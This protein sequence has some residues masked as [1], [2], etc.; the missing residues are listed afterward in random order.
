VLT[1]TGGHMV[2]PEYYSDTFARLAKSAGLPPIWLHDLRRASGITMLDSGVPVH[3]A[4]AWHGHDPS[5]TL[6][7]YGHVHPVG[8]ADAGSALGAAFE[9]R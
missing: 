2:R 9:Q 1:D 5:M 4:A 7:V 8:L 3:V 6:K